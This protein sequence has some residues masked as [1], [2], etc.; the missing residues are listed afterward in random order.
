M[1][2]KGNIIKWF[3]RIEFVKAVNTTKDNLM[4]TLIVND[5]GFDN[6]FSY[7]TSPS[8]N[9]RRYTNIFNEDNDLDVS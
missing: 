1:Y 2:K 5:I 6:I 4:I 8:V 3:H 7:Q 9:D